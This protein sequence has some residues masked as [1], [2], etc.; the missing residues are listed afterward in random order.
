MK[1]SKYLSY[2]ETVSNYSLDYSHKDNTYI[3][4]EKMFINDCLDLI[5][6][7]MFPHVTLEYIN[8]MRKQILL[9]IDNKKFE[10]HRKNFHAI[11]FQPKQKLTSIQIEIYQL[12]CM[13]FPDSYSAGGDPI[14]ECFTES[15][16]ATFNIDEDI[17]AEYLYK[18]FR[19][20]IG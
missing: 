11:V 10:Q 7:D 18:H 2:L 16:Y 3:K 12:I 17:I 13:L 5:D 4:R 9:A 15:L 14:V 8:T 1:T 19:D 6:L 20:I